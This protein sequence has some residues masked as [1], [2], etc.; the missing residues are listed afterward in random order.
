M[1]QPS[2]ILS[3]SSLCEDEGTLIIIW[4]FTKTKIFASVHIQMSDIF[5]S[6]LIYILF[7]LPL[8]SCPFIFSL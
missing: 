5:C 7:S 1:A 8:L 4:H 2:K 3:G 6:F